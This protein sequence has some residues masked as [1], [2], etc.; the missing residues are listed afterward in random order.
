[1]ADNVVNSTGIPISTDELDTLNGVAQTAPK[2]HA[3]RN[4]LVYGA[5]GIATDVSP[6]NGLPVQ[7]DHTT[8]GVTDRVAVDGILSLLIAPTLSVGGIYQAGDYVGITT[9]GIPINPATR[10]NGGGGVI[11]SLIMI[12]GDNQGAP[13][14]IFFF[15]NSNIAMPTDNAAW[16]LSDTS[17]GYIQGR[18]A[19]NYYVPYGG[20]GNNGQWGF[21]EFPD[22]P[23]AYQCLGS[24]LYMALV[25]RVGVTYTAVPSTTAGIRFRVQLRP[26]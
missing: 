4:K 22:G 18:A 8:P 6:T 23:V 3:Q 26:N 25:P 14:D 11:E 12:D 7:L 19:I 15:G 9:T 24:T 2:P 16:A 21:A 13:L 1:M 20:A 10:A 17:A 5:D